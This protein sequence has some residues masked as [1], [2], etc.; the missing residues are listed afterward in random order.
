MR[1]LAMLKESARRVANAYLE[2]DRG[3]FLPP[4][5]VNRE[6]RSL[7]DIGMSD[8]LILKAIS[9]KFDVGL[10]MAKQLL[11]EYYRSL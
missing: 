3:F 10:N 11:S 5:K 8:D 7:K 2:R 1:R 6:I 9:R 4:F